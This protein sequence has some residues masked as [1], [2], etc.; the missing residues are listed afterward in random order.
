MRSR[1]LII[2]EDLALRARLA[3]ALARGGY[4][5]EVAKSLAH[6][7]RAGL[8]GIALAIV[9]DGDPARALAVEELRAAVGRVLRVGSPGGSL[10]L[11]D[12]HDEASFL[13]GVRQAM[14]AGPEAEA[15]EPTIAFAGHRLDL[16]GHSLADPDGAN[17]P[18][19]RAEFS[20]LRAFAERP[21]RVLSRDQLLQ[22]IAGRDAE[23]YDRSIDMHVARLRRK[24]EPDPKRPSLIVTVP[25]SG[26][27]FAVAVGEAAPPRA[28]PAREAAPAPG[29][30]PGTPERRQVVALAAELVAQEGRRVPSDPEDLG[31]LVR[32]FRCDATAVLTRY[33]GVIAENRGREFLA[34]FGYPFAQEHAA[35]QALR[36]ALALVGRVAQGECGARVGVAAGLVVAYGG[37]EIFGETPDEARR[38]S[39]LARPGQAL[40]SGDARRQAEKLFQFRSFALAGQNGAASTEI[41]QVLA[42]SAAS[43]SEAIFASPKLDLIGRE[44]ELSLLVSAWRGARSGEGRLALLSGEPGI[45]KSRLLAALEDE[46]AQ[47]ALVSMRYF[48]SVLNRDSALYPVIARWEQEAGFVSGEPP[49]ARPGKLEA[50]YSAD[51]MSAEDFAR[52]AEML[53]VPCGERY[54][55]LDLTPQQRKQ[56]T[57]DALRR[58]LFN[59]AK[60]T[61]LLMLF[62][63]AHWA[64]ASSLELIDSVVSR[65]HDQPILLVVSC[66]PE[67]SPPWAGQAGVSAITLGRLNRRQ[68]AQLAAQIRGAR[69]ISPELQERILA[70]AD[71]VPLFIEELTKATLESA[72]SSQG[73]IPSTLSATLIQRLDRLP[74]AKQV[75]QVGAAIGREFSHALLSAAASMSEG[76]LARGLD[77]LVACGLAS[78]RGA[79]PEATYAF[80]HALVQDAVYDTLLK[81]RRRELHARVAGALRER[82]FDVAEQQPEVLAHHL[83]E[84]GETDPA[85]EWWGKAGDAALRRSAFQEAIAHL[86]KAIEMADGEGA[87]KRQE[88]PPRADAEAQTP[89]AE[90]AGSGDVEEAL[91][92]RQSRAALRANYAR[93]LMLGKGFARP[94][95]SA[96]AARAW[97]SS[98]A[99]SRARFEAMFVDWGTRLVA[100][101][102]A[103]AN[104]IAETFLSDA[105]AHGQASERRTALRIVGTLR[106]Y[107]GR[108]SEAEAALRAALDAPPPPDDPHER[109]RF[110][111]DHEAVT[112]TNFAAVKWL[113]GDAAQA[114]AASN[115]ALAAA[116]ATNHPPTL[117]IVR[118]YR[119]TLN[120]RRGDVDAVAREGAALQALGAAHGMPTYLAAGEVFTL[121]AHARATGDAKTVERLREA[122]RALES[123]RVR[124]NLP[125]SEA[126]LAEA[127]LAARQYDAALATADRALAFADA[128]GVAYENARLYRARAGALLAMT[129]ADP[130][131]AEAAYRMAI[132][133]ARAQGARTYELVAAVPLA[134]L[135]QANNRALEAYDALARALEGFA[136]TPELPQIAEAQALLAT[137]ECD[138]TVAAEVA[139]RKR[140]SGFSTYETARSSG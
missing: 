10:S 117:C 136:P 128:S 25:G 58:R 20:L 45:G 9:V 91:G 104:E 43:R 26:Y 60:K 134:E 63:D 133:T 31:A 12:A 22:L 80:K 57:F 92:K 38:L 83:T 120:M 64:D 127:E 116:E 66:R 27:K 7:R 14:A 21:G 81:S 6:A 8:A 70:Q 82:F 109:F 52:I 121:W 110:L 85:I 112:L 30:E 107:Q 87:P 139:R 1:V 102:I 72:A 74:G 23:P 106:L 4:R 103:A 11:A 79:S 132:E 5:A 93:A 37:G 42:P 76:E 16:A 34:Y 54:P 56:K 114:L 65:L 77:G 41:W 62:E 78:R 51:K 125:S 108:L 61:P 122:R 33:G 97:E 68:S 28:E 126:A 95:T 46:L 118:A 36:A 115:S 48:C 130:G 140:L 113:L 73:A 138:E 89:L 90:L 53:S 124:H 135:F 29:A 88:A 69:R 131:R 67:F 35:E 129:P 19:T 137:V 94:E 123:S 49:E 59:A 119:G 86:G 101:E 75:A 47:E 96:A 24:I 18:L 111:E 17:V 2:G 40:V 44:E 100:G 3:Q 55:R 13:A 98:G 84:A 71:G 32:A 105:E 99:S 50:L 15:A 39:A